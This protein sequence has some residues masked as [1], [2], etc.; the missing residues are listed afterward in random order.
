[1]V[2]VRGGRLGARGRSCAAVALTDAAAV[3][4]SALTLFTDRAAMIVLHLLQALFGRFLWLRWGGVRY[5]GGWSEGRPHGP[6]GRMRYPS[7][8]RY[9]G[10]FA[11]GAKHGRGVLHHPSGYRYE[12]D[13]L[14]GCKTGHARIRYKNGDRYEGAVRA[15]LREG[16]GTLVIA[17]SGRVVTGN[18]EADSPIGPCRVEAEGW[19]FEGVLWERDGTGEG[20][21]RRADGTH[22]RGRV[23]HFEPAG[24]G[25]LIRPDGARLVGA[26][27]GFARVEA[28]TF[29]DGDGVVWQ[30]AFLD[31]QP[32]GIMRVKLPNGRVYEGSWQHGV[33]QRVIASRMRHRPEHG[34]D[35]RPE[36][37]PD[38][39]ARL[40]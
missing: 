26:W 17:A 14:L 35:D 11:Q 31:Q 18:W 24:W 19:R 15:G 32:H 39:S 37:R 40:H 13:W 10:G 12:G 33:R 4:S 2:A 36:L 27:Q 1:M 5:R 21:I 3:S 25:T 22:Y 6:G 8:A 9:A 28:A 20:Q 34:P 30:G 29:T 7:G 16:A 23:R 38:A